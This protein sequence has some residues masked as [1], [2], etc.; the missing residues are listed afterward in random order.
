MN[1]R[2]F[3]RYS[4]FCGL[5]ATAGSLFSWA[6]APQA[7][8]EDKPQSE[9]IKIIDAH[10]HP[11][12]Y[13]YNS[14]PTD[15][16]S[17][18]MAIK[19]LG[20]VASCFAAVGDSVFLSQGRVPGTEYHS[21][22]TQLEWWLK[23]IIKSGRVKLVLKASDVPEAIGP[24]IAPGAILSI[25]GGDPLEGSLSRVDEFYRL[26][27]R[28]ITL[29]HYRNNELG[30]IMRMWRSLDPGSEHNG[31]TPAG[32]KVVERMQ[33]VG[34]VVDV[35]HAHSLTLRQI[36][37]MSAKPLLDSHT[38]PCHIEDPLRCGRSRTW[39]DMEL[40]ARTGGV[41][42]TWPIAYKRGPTIRVSFLDWAKEILEMKNRLGMNHVGL[43]TDGG[44]NLPDLIEGYRDVRDLVKLKV[45]MQE[46]SFSQEEIGAYMGGNFYR[47]LKSCIG[48]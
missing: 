19:K 46:V 13:V 8:T 4:V 37:E 11:D 22:K 1:R 15:D 26:G 23:G 38:N 48:A 47:V 45:A 44:G 35:A 41:V 24:D 32:H 30:D 43:G 28:M 2:E 29:M 27:V 21:T 39:K 12:R 25:E 18:L 40:V 3:L 34:M 42:C 14:R 20:M 16:T 10:A 36:A 5:S 7:S 6:Q 31:L 33:N 17:T 9:N